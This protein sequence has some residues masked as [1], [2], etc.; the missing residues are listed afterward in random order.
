MSHA[1]YINELK[2][3]ATNMLGFFATVSSAT[4]GA[5]QEES[6]RADALYFTSLTV[7]ILTTVHLS[8]QIHNLAR[9]I[10]KQRKKNEL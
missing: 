2:H 7:G 8:M 6:W 10:I 4:V 1:F 3:H 9:A 5:A